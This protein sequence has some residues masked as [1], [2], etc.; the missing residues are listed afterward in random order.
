MKHSPSFIRR[1]WPL[2]AF[3]ILLGVFLTAGL[4]MTHQAS[5]TVPV[6]TGKAATPAMSTNSQP[7]GSVADQLSDEF[8][9]V[10]KQVNPSVV[11]IFTEE[12]IKAPQSQNPFQGTPFE[13]FFGG[14]Q[15]QGNYTRMGL[16]S[17][18]IYN[19]NGTILT[20]NHVV[21]GAD[22]IKV[23]LMDGREFTAKVKGRDPQTDLAVITIDAKNLPAIKLGNSD[24]TR[25]GDWVLA[26]GSPL[27]PQLE[28]TV[29]AGIISAKGRTLEGLS[30]KTKY[31]DYLQTDAA[32]NPGNSGGALV[33]TNGELIGIN[34]A[35][36]S[37]T[38]GFQ[39]IGFAIPVN[40]AQRVAGE[41]IKTGKVTRGWLGV[42]IQDINP[43]LAKALNL[44][45]TNGVVITRVQSNSPAAK[46]GL[47]KEDVIQQ[48]DGKA[49]ENADQLSTWVASTPPGAS[50]KMQ[51]L[52]N[53]KSMTLTVKLGELTQKQMAQQEGKQSF[54]TLGLSVADI[55]PDAVQQYKLSSNQTGVVV[56]NVAPN[57]IAAQFGMQAGDVI[58]EVDHQPVKSM[59]DFSSIMQKI[60]PG[61]TVLFYLER[62]QGSF[63]V[64]FPMPEK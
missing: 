27:N 47:K 40:L 42:A 38:G 26:I 11:T 32:I 13:Q 51:I 10:A 45:T 63:F 39:G 23:Q 35:I 17:G 48:F 52:R 50:A 29:T 6:A 14:P 30:N 55:T 12:T 15:R 33:N 28:H 58:T 49:L 54:S 16:G 9:A 53:G 61:E 21:E 25:V 34:S 4:T 18:V 59:K 2:I 22:N 3:G 8:A 43:Q 41:L 24:Q 46:A 64:A 1:G 20:N 7:S 57:G 44:Q 36:A 60:K 31:Q 5:A 19:S 62:G 37:Q 56:T